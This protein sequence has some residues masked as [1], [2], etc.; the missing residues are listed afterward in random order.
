LLPAQ[1][2]AT[3]GWLA[4]VGVNRLGQGVGKDWSMGP[5]L[6]LRR[7]LGDHFAVDFEATWL[8]HNSVE[9][10]YSGVMGSLGPA[11]AWRV[12]VTRSLSGL[13]LWPRQW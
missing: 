6:S 1:E 7:M 10:V 9:D 4:V 2:S 5:A 13:G 12:N 11:W 3:K 8:T